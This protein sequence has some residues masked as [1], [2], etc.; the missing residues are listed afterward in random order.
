MK[1]LTFIDEGN[2]DFIKSDNNSEK[3]I[4]FAKRRQIYELISNSVLKFQKGKYSEIEYIENVSEYLS[5]NMIKQ[6]DDILEQQSMIREPR[7][8]TRVNIIP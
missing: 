2:P 6:T 7:N 3:L 4:N 8:S 1:D 5:Y